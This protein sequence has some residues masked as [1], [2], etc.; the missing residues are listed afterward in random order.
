MGQWSL[1]LCILYLVW[2]HNGLGVVNRH[3]LELCVSHIL[4]ANKNIPLWYLP[5]QHI[6]ETVLIIAHPSFSFATTSSNISSLDS[7]T[8]NMSFHGSYGAS[9]VVTPPVQ[10]CETSGYSALSNWDGRVGH[11]NSLPR[12]PPH[13]APGFRSFDDLTAYHFAAMRLSQHL[14]VVLSIHLTDS[15][16]RRPMAIWSAIS[17]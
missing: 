16:R 4:F 6:R 17:S 8:T 5:L 9:F 10:T 2:H 11:E 1:Q 7:I 14:P 15:L 13:P 3:S 12:A